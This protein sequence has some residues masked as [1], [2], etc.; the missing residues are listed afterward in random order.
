MIFYLTAC[1]L[2]KVEALFDH[3][4][5]QVVAKWQPS[6]AKRQPITSLMETR[7]SLLVSECVQLD[8]I[9]P[10]TGANNTCTVISKVS[11]C[12]CGPGEVKVR[13]YLTWWRTGRET[14][15]PDSQ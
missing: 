7:L 13:S 5:N 12:V 14:G 10:Q 15:D 11:V 3:L 4:T 2:Q 8:L 9:L 6:V 1:F